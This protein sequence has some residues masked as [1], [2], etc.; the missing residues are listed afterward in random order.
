MPLGRNDNVATFS[1]AD[2]FKSFEGFCAKAEVDYKQ[3]QANPIIAIPAQA[4]S[5][6]EESND[7]FVGG[8]DPGIKNERIP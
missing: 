3:E 7:D 1:Q 8:D 6:D 5:D 2:G 4:V